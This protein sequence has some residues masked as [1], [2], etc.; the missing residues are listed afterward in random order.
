MGQ[1][2]DFVSAIASLCNGKKT[3]KRG[4]HLKRLSFFV[5][6]KPIQTFRQLK[7]SH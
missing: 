6:C 3:V 7:I 4:V 2:R 1:H 5:K